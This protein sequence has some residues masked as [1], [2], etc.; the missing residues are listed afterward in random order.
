MQ[1]NYAHEQQ[2]PT[3]AMRVAL[4]SKVVWV[5]DAVAVGVR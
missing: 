5:T 3:P 2:V 4:Q 1:Q